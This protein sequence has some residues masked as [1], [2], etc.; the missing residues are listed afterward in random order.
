MTVARIDT[1][2]KR[3][4]HN[5]RLRLRAEGRA[6]FA[7]QEFAPTPPYPQDTQA[8]HEWLHGWWSVHY[9]YYCAACKKKHHVQSCAELR[10][11]L[12]AS[13]PPP[14]VPPGQDEYPGIDYPEDEERR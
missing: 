10:G 4:Q 12:F 7:G 3:A 8:Y 6:A 5:I 11:L 1:I 14:D 2:A 13:D 9:G